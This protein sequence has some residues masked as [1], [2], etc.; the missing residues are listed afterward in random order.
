MGVPAEL[1][2]P[3]I[4]TDDDITTAL[5]LISRLGLTLEDLAVGL[6]KARRVPTFR[7][8]IERLSAAVPPTTLRSY[9]TYWRVL[10]RAWG[11]RLLSEPTVL[12]IE[13]LITHHR[14]HAVVRANSR[15]GHGATIN[16]VAAVRCLYRHAERDKLI[17]PY[18]NPATKVDKPASLPSPRHALSLEQVQALAHVAST[19]GN[20]PALDA[21][22]VRLHIETACRR[23]GAL[24]LGIEDLN[25][26]D[27]LI[28]LREKGFTA[29]WQPISPKL[30]E[31]LLN[32]IA[33][34]G[35]R[36]ATNRLFRYSNGRP[37][38]RRRYDYLSQRFRQELSWAAALGV[39]AHWIRHTTLTFVE[40]EFGYA[41]AR[42]YAGHANPGG[43]L[44]A[45]HTYVR[46]TIVEVAEALEALTGEPHPLAPV[47]R[48][49][50]ADNRRSIN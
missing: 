2:A 7:D 6:P 25:P 34:R 32:H 31:Y 10:E 28:Y 3:F 18:D 12:E 20:D 14:S 36:D 41:V 23:G 13:A 35:G 42:A 39:T 21:L 40:R 22:I 29:R 5:H 38:G 9:G 49:P 26:D 1:L 44:G 48:H 37:V 50:L 30:M 19:T 27:S 15:D 45:T 11:D 24:R 16:F 46:A 43:R 4:M 17:H 47:D 33:H 8:Y